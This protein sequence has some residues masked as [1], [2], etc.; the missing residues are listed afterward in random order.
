MRSV[1]GV[2]SAVDPELCDA[3]VLNT[4]DLTVDMLLW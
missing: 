2:G 1:G 3:H 4:V